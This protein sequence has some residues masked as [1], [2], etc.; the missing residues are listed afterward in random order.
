M[1][2]IGSSSL[3]HALLAF[4]AHSGIWPLRSRFNQRHRTMARA[5]AGVVGGS[6]GS[7]CMVVFAFRTSRVSSYV[8]MQSFLPSGE[9]HEHVD[10]GPCRPAKAVGKL[11][12]ANIT[13]H[14][15]LIL[16]I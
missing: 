8:Q 11:L 1:I 12:R 16:V 15:V 14:K 6:G 4:S 5:H 10:D 13:A 2:G 3:P 7:I 9:V